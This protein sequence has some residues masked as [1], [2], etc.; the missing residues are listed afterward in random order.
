[1]IIAG[2]MLVERTVMTFASPAAALGGMMESG[3]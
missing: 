1:M 3:W 2:E